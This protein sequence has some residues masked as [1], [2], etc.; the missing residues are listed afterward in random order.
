MLLLPVEKIEEYFYDYL[1]DKDRVIKSYPGFIKYLIDV[2]KF[3]KSSVADIKKRFVDDVELL[4]FIK[5]YCEGD[6]VDKSLVGLA[7]AS[8]SQF[9][10]K[11]KHGYDSVAT[12]AA[13]TLPTI[14][15]I[16]LDT[17]GSSE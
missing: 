11:N 4:N 7:N 3:D 15:N 13:P 6:L 16:V 12:E 5:S 14:V 17:K 9:I 8:M 2:K 1:K 10:L